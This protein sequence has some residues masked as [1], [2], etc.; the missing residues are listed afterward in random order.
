MSIEA[1]QIATAVFGSSTVGLAVIGC[2]LKARLDV[3]R[4]HVANLQGYVSDQCKRE[5]ELIR[6]RD[7]LLRFYNRVSKQRQ[8]ALKVA[9]A[10]RA[11]KA[12][13][14]AEAQTAAREKTLHALQ[15]TPLRSR[16]E[17]VADVKRAAAQV[18]SAN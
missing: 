18:S 15:V 8:D 11:A 9:A 10:K 7:E 16:A 13:E 6:E 2:A 12:G 3:A 5:G 17:V 4:D 1:F 14:T